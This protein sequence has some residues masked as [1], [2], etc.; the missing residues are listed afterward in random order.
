MLYEIL[1]T[2]RLELIER[3]RAKVARR[4]AP[5]RKDAALE[6]GIPLFI[7]QLIDTLRA[8]KPYAPPLVTGASE[9]GVE[10]KTIF[11]DVRGSAVRH[12]RELL[13]NG[14]SVDQVVHDYGDLCQAV[15][16]LAVEYGDPIEIE[17]F[18]ILNLCLDNA[19]ADAVVAYSYGKNALIAEQGLLS[20][21]ERLG[22]LAHELRNHIQ[23]ASLALVAI[24]SG[25]VALAGSTGAVLERSLIELRSL[26][27]RSLAD[28]RMTAGI[29]VRCEVISVADLIGQV[30]GAALLEAQ[31]RDCTLMIPAVAPELTMNVDRELLLSAVGN[32]L[33]N[34]FKFTAPGTDVS[35]H[36]C[37]KGDRI[38]IEVSDHC[39][40]LPLGDVEQLFQPFTQ[41]S[42]DKS[43]VGL[44]L[45][46]CRRS[47]EA[48]QG[49][50]SVRDVPGEGCVFTVDLP[51][52][53]LTEDTQLSFKPAVVSAA[54]QS[55]LP[56]VRDINLGC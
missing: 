35:L 41:R 55:I 27:D 5:D 3:C 24:K 46:I 6:H 34:A 7:N 14:F 29:D 21:N 56:P 32:L 18:R 19:I 51:R 9:A 39:G 43:G 13:Q 8:E 10:R 20:L 40:G 2:H 38:L 42:T 44:G 22:Y 12:G 33:Q 45:S 28:V 52:Y 15:T 4:R 1:T 48:N 26:V 53:F 17:E 36:V 23:T 49:I 31:A 37:A 11:A 50:L 16:E 30:R 47:V 54:K 25:K